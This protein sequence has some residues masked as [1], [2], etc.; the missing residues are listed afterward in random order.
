MVINAVAYS[1][2]LPVDNDVG[3]VFFGQAF[4]F[5]YGCALFSVLG[6]NAFI[7]FA[8]YGPIILIGNY[9]LV[10]GFWCVARAVKKGF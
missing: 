1:A 4:G 6:G 2:I 3:F 5:V 10:P 9:M 8:A 7:A